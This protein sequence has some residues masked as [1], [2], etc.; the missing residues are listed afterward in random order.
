M[1]LSQLSYADERCVG[2]P[3]VSVPYGCV[4]GGGVITDT[5]DDHLDRGSGVG[6]EDQVKLVRVGIEESKC[7]FSDGIDA[8]TCQC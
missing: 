3:V 4:A 5:L 6:N 2:V 1:Q 8:V 7:A